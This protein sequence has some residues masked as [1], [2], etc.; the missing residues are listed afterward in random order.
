M[1]DNRTPTIPQ[2]QDNVN[3]SLKRTATV[4][5][6]TSDDRLKTI[7]Q[8]ENTSRVATVLANSSA[9]E[10][11]EMNIFDNSLYISDNE[12]LE[13]KI[14]KEDRVNI[15]S[16]ES[17]TYV[18]FGTTRPVSFNEEMVDEINNSNNPIDTFSRIVRNIQNLDA[19]SANQR[20]YKNDEDERI[21]GAYSL[22]E[23]V[24]TI[25]PYKPSVEF[26]NLDIVKNDDIA[27]W[28]IGFVT[29]NGDE[30]DPNSYQVIGQ[31]DYNDFIKKLPKDKYRF[32]DASYILVEPLSKEE[33]LGLLEISVN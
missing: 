32:I 33:I 30:N 18:I 17:D 12:Y 20:F 21:M 8:N 19:Y 25:L 16:G 22:T 4:A 1:N 31:L 29:I 2:N 7:P 26:H 14:K 24:R 15:K 5:Q 9:D 10:I 13:L 27:F 28:N 23:N 3:E 11:E 6:N